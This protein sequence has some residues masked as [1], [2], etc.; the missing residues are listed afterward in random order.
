MSPTRY[1]TTTWSPTSRKPWYWP[2][3]RGSGPCGIARGSANEPAFAQPGALFVSATFWPRMRTIGPCA[4]SYA[5]PRRC[6]HPSVQAAESR[7]NS[8]SNATAPASPSP[9]TTPFIVSPV[10]PP[11]SNVVIR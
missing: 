2:Q 4:P 8:V 3:L 7:S 6:S 11:P 9:T 1:S 5:V 10:R